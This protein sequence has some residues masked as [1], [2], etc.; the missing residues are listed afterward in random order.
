MCWPIKTSYCTEHSYS[1]SLG[2][3]DNMKQLLNCRSRGRS[4]RLKAVNFDKSLELVAEITWLAHRNTVPVL[5]AW[6]G[7]S[8]FWLLLKSASR[9]L[10]Q[11]STISGGVLVSI[12]TIS[13]CR[14]RTKSKSVTLGGSK[15][16]RI[17]TVR[18]P[19]V[20]GMIRRIVELLLPIMTAFSNTWVSTG[21]TSLNWS[22]KFDSSTSCYFHFLG[23]ARWPFV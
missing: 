16:T 6:K 23:Y 2:V 12:A 11:H 1:Y 22:N 17:S 13:L 18:W 10:V 15:S 21:P 7:L 5:E 3:P 19:E 4:K 14:R 9:E 20:H 8:S